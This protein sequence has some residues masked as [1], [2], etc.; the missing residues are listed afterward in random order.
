MSDVKFSCPSCCQTGALD[1]PTLA[2]FGWSWATLRFIGFAVFLFEIT[3]HI[4]AAAPGSLDL[5]FDPGTAV[6]T[7]YNGVVHAVLADPAGGVVIG[8]EFTLVDG[9]SRDNIARLVSNGSVDAG[10]RA[11]V[12]HLAGFARVGVLALEGAQILV[13]GTFDSVNGYARQG[14]AR[15]NADGTLD[16]TFNPSLGDF[17]DVRVILVQPDGKLIVGGFAVSSSS[18]TSYR[19][20][21]VRLLP[22]GKLDL[23]FDVGFGAVGGFIYTGALQPDGKVLVGGFGFFPSSNSPANLARFNS[24]GALDTRYSPALGTLGIVN[25]IA[26]QADGRAVIAGDFDNVNG[27]TR[28]GYA[29]VNTDGTLDATFELHDSATNGFSAGGRLQCVVIQ[30]D[31]K[32][33]IGGTFI[34]SSG[35]IEERIARFL[36]N[37]TP[38]PSFVS[39]LADT[40]VETL[41]LQRDSKILVGGQFHDLAGI[42]RKSIARLQ[43]DTAEPDRPIVSLQ[44]TQDGA[45]QLTSTTQPGLRYAID[46][47]ADLLSWSEVTNFVAS[48][49]LTQIADPAAHTL[50]RRFYRARLLP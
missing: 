29:R 12:T 8:G 31:Q 38:D 4:N 50:D 15:L 25:S 45:T 16:T 48:S 36:P 33:L 18:G 39:L 49:R 23:T 6:G 20:D 30:S 9:A 1:V 37:G 21:L 27:I 11:R 2:L 34:P 7:N 19:Y 42:Q 24:N 14:I 47:S 46:G 40:S 22:D 3:M 17:P 35:G 32:I 28:Y 5:G 26:V 13:G 44:L 43:G 41:A 10:F